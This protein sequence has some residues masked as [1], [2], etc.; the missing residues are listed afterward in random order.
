MSVVIAWRLLWSRHHLTLLL[1]VVAVGGVGLGVLVLT[2]VLSVM[3]GFQSVLSSKLVALGN[4]LTVVP[5][6]GTPWRQFSSHLLRLD[7]VVAAAP[8]LR[9]EGLLV[10]NGDMSP[11]SVTGI[12]PKS[13]SRVSDLGSRLIYGNLEVLSDRPNSIVVGRALARSLDLSRGSTVTLLTVRHAGQFVPRATRMY[14]AG[15]YHVGIYEVESHLIYTGFGTMQRM[16]DSPQMSISLRLKNPFLASNLAQ[17]LRTELGPNYE[18]SDWEEQQAG[19]ASTIDLEKR[20][21]FFVLSAI[22]AVAAFTVVATLVVSGLDR[23]REMAI[24]ATLGYQ[25]AQTALV[26]FWQGAI[27][28]AIGTGLGLGLGAI[29][30]V[31]VNRILS[32][33]DGWFHTH[34]LPPS[35]Y[36]ISELP[37]RFDWRELLATALVA[38]SLCLLAAIY[39]AVRAS[40]RLP[41]EAL[42]YAR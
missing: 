24:L 32:A 19:V 4:E 31:N 14:V 10:A 1:A 23:E 42:R 18:V 22:L 5:P 36:L 27:L 26:F 11:V 20:M 34:L 15:V 29:L 8:I 17:R 13:E 21:V 9:G 39:P 2:S 28:G 7:N 37:A 35:I 41:A 25:P 16:F 40:R 12:Q 30:A 6:V 33:L 3:S 38:M